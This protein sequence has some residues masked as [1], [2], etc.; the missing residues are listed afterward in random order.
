MEF[1]YSDEGQIDWL[2]GYV[3]PAR[4]DALVASGA[5]PAD[6]LSSLPSAAAY[7]VTKIPTLDQVTNIQKVVTGGWDSTVGATVK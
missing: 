4:F 7:S 1:L 5:V 6:V 2:R 3:H